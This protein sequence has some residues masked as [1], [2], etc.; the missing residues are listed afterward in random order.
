MANPQQAQI[1]DRSLHWVVMNR[2]QLADRYSVVVYLVLLLA[3]FAIAAPAVFTLGSASTVVQLSIPLLV[4]SLAMTFCLVC[5]E[6]D[7]SVG[8]VAGVASTIAALLMDHGF[9]WPLAV[10][11]ALAAGC[12]IGMINGT[13]TVL[14]V[15]SFPRFPS[16]L[17]T[18]ATLVAATGAAQLLQPLQQ[19][20]AIDNQ[21]FKAAF[22][23]G[24]SVLGSTT[25]WY[26]ILVLLAAHFVLTRTTFGHALYAVGSNVRA[27]RFVG[28]SVLRIKF[29]VLTLSGILSAFAGILMAGFVQAGFSSI[30]DGVE[31]D[32]IAAAVI[33]GA[34]LAG[35]RGTALGTLGG[36]LI[37]GLMNTG[38]LI[39][40]IPT[41]WQMVSKGVLVV[42][43]LASAEFLRRRSEISKQSARAEP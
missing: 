33:G 16:F 28:Y 30:A 3:A 35:G 14:L 10:L 38:L 15:P 34:S 43:A 9:G 20:V 24:T 26:A 41:N 6:I 42:L 37:L 11:V 39:V 36:A 17:V 2:W 32:A 40:E 13:L 29:A 21:S 18:L 25:F 19:A 5:G 27:A 1:V 23:Y 22:S 4:F 8:G 31:I 7:L 12:A